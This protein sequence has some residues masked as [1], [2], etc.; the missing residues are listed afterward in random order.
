MINKI[1]ENI[2]QLHFNAFSCCVYILKINNKNILIDTGSKAARE[3]LI[4]DLKQINLTP[5]NIDTIILT[6]NHYDHIENLEIFPKA[7]LYKAEELNEKSIIPELPDMQIISTPG[8]AKESKCFLYQDILFSGD[9]IFHNGYV[10]RTDLPGSEPEKLQ[11]SIEKLE[12][13]D[14][15]ILCPGHLL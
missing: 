11:P 8:H 3:E 6:H 4:E 9:T 2:S 12:K 7:K 1:K 13:L 14:Y 15:K 10:G 5:E